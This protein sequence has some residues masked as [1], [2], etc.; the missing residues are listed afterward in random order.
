[1]NQTMEVRKIRPQSR[2]HIYWPDTDDR[3]FTIDGISLG[4]F[5]SIAISE[6]GGKY[7][8]RTYKD[9]IEGFANKAEAFRIIQ[10]VVRGDLKC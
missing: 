5:K 3:V 6:S 2:F 4:M 1:M 10:A 7:V 8:Y 9:S